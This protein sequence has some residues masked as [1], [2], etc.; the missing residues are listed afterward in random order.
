LRLLNELVQ[1]VNFMNG[2]F[3]HKIHNA[4][5]VRLNPQHGALV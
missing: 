3:L 1:D 5:L 4:E 2:C